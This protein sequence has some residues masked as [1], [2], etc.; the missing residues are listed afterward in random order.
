MTVVFALGMLA[1]LAYFRDGLIQEMGDIAVSLESL[2]QEFEYT[3]DGVTTTS[4]PD[5]TSLTDPLNGAPA[6][7]SLSDTPPG[8]G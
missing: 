4:P 8:E 5:N 6:G 7:L 3:V 2:D 1:G